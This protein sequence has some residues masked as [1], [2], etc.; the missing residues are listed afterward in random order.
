M[1]LAE[2]AVD[3][4]EDGMNCS[5]AVLIALGTSMGI[6]RRTAAG[7]P[8]AFGCGMA[9]TGQTCGAVTGGLMVIGLHCNK[10][11]WLASRK[12]SLSHALVLQRK[13]THM[14]CRI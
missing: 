8:S 1:T 2:D 12:M 7:V 6:D 3:L 9:C 10:A 4:M 14:V 5:Q 11:R 13:F